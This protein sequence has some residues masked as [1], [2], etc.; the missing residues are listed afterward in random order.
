MPL[1]VVAGGKYNLSDKS[2]MNY[3]LDF[4]KT[5]HAQM[6]FQHQ[7]DDK[8]SAGIH[9]TYDFAEKNPYKVG[10]SAEYTL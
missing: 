1:Q 9:Q 2:T 6:A 4:E 10:L 7:I 8:W 3:S 5:A